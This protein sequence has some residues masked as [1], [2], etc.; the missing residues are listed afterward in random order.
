[1]IIRK[2]KKSDANVV[3]K[4]IRKNDL[5]VA[6][7]FYPKKVV[8]ARLKEITPAKILKKSL[9]RICYVADENKKIIGYI[10]LSGNEIK[11]LFVLPKFHK[12]GIGRKL[13]SKIEKIAKKKDIKK[14]I[15]YSNFYTEEFYK[16]CGFRRLK[17]VWEKAGDLK[18]KQIYMEKNLKW[19]TF[20]QHKKYMKFYQN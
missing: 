18:Y 4:L 6:V 16:K 12:K 13:L 14:L 11:K 10:S 20:S 9:K 5:E 1:M 3:S 8:I 15:L 17:I 7:K 19:F 2:F